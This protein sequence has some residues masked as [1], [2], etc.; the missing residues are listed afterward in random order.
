MPLLALLLFFGSFTPSAAHAQQ[1]A[2]PDSLVA[3]PSPSFTHP[4]RRCRDE[5]DPQ[6][7]SSAVAQ[8]R[9]SGSFGLPAVAAR[10]AR[11]VDEPLRAQMRAAITAALED[12]DAVRD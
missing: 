11:L 9:C 4:V 1:R 6:P 7:G 12:R 10:R 3:T 8:A 2:A 5:D